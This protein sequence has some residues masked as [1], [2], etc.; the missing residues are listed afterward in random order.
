MVNH[1]HVVHLANK[2]LSM[3]RHRTGRH[4]DIRSGPN[5]TKESEMQ[6]APPF[7]SGNYAPVTDEITVC[8]LKVE[9]V[10]PAELTGWYLR[11]GPNPHDAKSVHW[12]LGDGMVHGVRLENGKATSYRNRWVRTSTLLEGKRPSDTSGRPD[13]TA[14]TANTHVV[15]HAGRIFALVESSFPYELEADLDTIGPYDFG[16]CLTT[17]MTAHPKICPETGELHFFGYRAASPPYLTYH[18]ADAAGNLVISRPVEEVGPT[19]MHDFALTSQHVIFMDLPV[20]FDLGLARHG[21]TMPYRWADNYGARLGVLRRDD[22]HGTI[23]WFTI[24]PCYVFHTLN[25]HDA[26]GKVVLTVVRYPELWRDDQSFGQKGTL[27]RWTI[28]LAKGKVTEEQLDDHDCEFPRIDDRLAGLDARYGCTIASSHGGEAPASGLLLRY[29]LHTA[30]VQ[31]HVYQPGQRPS[32]ASFAPADETP[33]GAGW[34][35]SYVYN[36]ERHTSDL[37]ILDAADI[38]AA[39]VATIHLPRRVPFGFHGNWLPDPP[40]TQP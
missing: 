32:E 3:V 8:E 33:G 9:G 37:V 26:G 15:R 16:G 36:A 14:G 25:A 24:D 35:M 11:N 17:P 31:E 13:L 28:D 40:A 29:D 22:P 4:R 19:M 20:V 10:I 1:F 18:R 30:S 38:A 7:L 6:Q 39:P 12:F 5:E 23:R 2:M 21:G 34:L 27:W